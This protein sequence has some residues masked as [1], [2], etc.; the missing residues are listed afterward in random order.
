MLL[1][2]LQPLVFFAQHKIDR[3]VSVVVAVELAHPFN[4]GLGVVTVGGATGLIG[5][6]M[7]GSQGI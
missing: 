2:E 7:G 6:A 5:Q 4:A 1:L 3:L